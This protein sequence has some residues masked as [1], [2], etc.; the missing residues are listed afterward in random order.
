M[1]DNNE[2]LKTAEGIRSVIKTYQVKNELTFKEDTHT[3]FIKNK[4]NKI[5]S[6]MPSVSTIIESFF[7]PF[8]PESTR[9]FKNCMGDK[10]RETKLLKEW[11]DSGTYAANKGSRAHYML[12]K[13][14]INTY[15]GFKEIRKPLFSCDDTQI[16][17]SD[18]MI[19]AGNDFLNLM[20]KR[21]AVM[22]DTEIVLGNIELGYF[23]QPDNVWLMKTEEDKIGMV[24]TDWKTN[25][26]KNFQAQSYT[27]KMKYPFNKYNST[28]LEHYFVQIPLYGKLLLKMLENTQFKNIPL[29]GGVVVLLKKDA[30]FSE[31]RIPRYFFNTIE[32]MNVKDYI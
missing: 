27:K 26:P 12:E 14:L 30:T 18:N 11:A 24:I 31:Y 16:K 5:I 29:L 21:G 17:D 6:D 22:L 9:A 28:A 3:Y 19:N 2:I 7:E 25:K 32:S 1:T 10:D 4:Q 15:N 13:K 23:G 8:K 20:H